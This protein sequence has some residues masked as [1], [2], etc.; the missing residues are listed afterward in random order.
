MSENS[1]VHSFSDGEVRF[2]L[3]NGT[4][5]IKAAT[6]SGDP[7]ELTEAEAKELALALLQSV[8]ER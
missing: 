5:H 1:E 3:V 8:E 6:A 2:W 7:V 4:V